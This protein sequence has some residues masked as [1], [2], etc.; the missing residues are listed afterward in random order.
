MGRLTSRRGLIGVGQDAIA[1]SYRFNS[2]IERKLAWKP[3]KG[4]VINFKNKYYKCFTCK[5]L[6]FCKYFKKIDKSKIFCSKSC[7]DIYRRK[8]SNILS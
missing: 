7:R 6:S 2:K 1:N 5:K 3:Q 8:E 4:R